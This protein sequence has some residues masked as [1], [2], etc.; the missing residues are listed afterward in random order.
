MAAVLSQ[1][2]PGRSISLVH[3]WNGDLNSG[4]PNCWLEGTSLTV[5]DYWGERGGGREFRRIIDAVRAVAAER[6]WSHDE[7]KAAWR[8]NRPAKRSARKR[9]L[10]RSMKLSV[11]S[12]FSRIAAHVVPD[13]CRRVPFIVA[14]GVRNCRRV[15]VAPVCRGPVRWLLESLRSASRRVP[16]LPS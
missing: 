1:N 11:Q 16:F 3:M 14:P 10:Q 4:V 8:L 9:L 5:K 12:S 2:L 13:C 15:T 6:R 7:A